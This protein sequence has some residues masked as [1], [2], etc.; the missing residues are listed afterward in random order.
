MVFVGDSDAWDMINVSSEGGSPGG[1]QEQHNNGDLRSNQPGVP[2]W[3]LQLHV[4]WL[5]RLTCELL[6]IWFFSILR[7]KFLSGGDLKNLCLDFKLRFMC[8]HTA[9]FKILHP[10]FLGISTKIS[11]K[12]GRNIIQSIH[13]FSV[14]PRIYISDPWA[15]IQE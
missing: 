15:G 2:C 4:N 5:D 7:E 13:V 10:R 11:W 14:V 12:G 6:A 3:S 8:P 1:G 9:V